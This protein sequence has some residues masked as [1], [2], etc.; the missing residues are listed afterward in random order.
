MKRLCSLALACALPACTPEMNWREV[1]ADDGNAS[2]M[3]PCRPDRHRRDVALAGTTVKMDLL[4]CTAGGAT[5]ALSSLALADPSEVTAALVALRAAMLDNLG[6]SV[7]RS[8]SWALAGM[9]PNAQAARV[10]ASGRL[11]DG[12]AVRQEAAF[13]A[14]GLHIYQASIIGPHVEPEAAENFF[15]GLRLQAP[16]LGR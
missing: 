11:P 3:L 1:R 4:V 5:F 14:R 7:L 6:G 16:G 10:E 2:V 9:T 8:T 12:T 13:F 15:G